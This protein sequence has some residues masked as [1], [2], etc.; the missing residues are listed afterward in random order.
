MKKKYPYAKLLLW[1]MAVLYVGYFSVFTILRIKGLYSHYFDLG[2]MHQTVFNT[3]EAIRTFDWSRFMELANPHGTGFV[4]RMAVHNDILL[5]VLAPLYFIYNGPQTLVVLQTF[6]LGAGA[7]AVFGIVRELM[8]KAKNRD[9]LAVVFVFTYLMYVPMQR[10]NIFDFHAVTFATTFI[11]CMFY[12]WLKKRYVLSFLFV[13]LT[14]LT[15]EQIG[16]TTFLIAG[17]M[18]VPK[19]S[20]RH[21]RLPAR[22]EAMSFLKDHGVR[23]SLIVMAVS[24]AWFV[25]SMKVIIP[26]YNNGTHFAIGYYSVFK[27]P[28][29]IGHYI[30][31]TST[32][33]YFLYL[34]GPLAFL[35][36]VSPLFFLASGFEFAINLLSDEWNMRNIIYHYTAVITPLL[37][38][39]AIY[40]AYRIISF[41]ARHKKEKLATG[42]IASLLVGLTLFFSWWKGPLPYSLE[43]DIFPLDNPSPG[44]NEVAQWG[45]ILK[46]EKI[47][48]SSNGHLAPFFSSRRYYYYFP[49]GYDKADYVV[50]QLSELYNY[51]DPKVDI[52]GMYRRLQADQR[53]RLIYQGNDIEVYQKA[54][55]TVNP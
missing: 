49:N 13:F 51:F 16:P 18:L 46:N 4:K 31:Q 27:N 21:L 29:S 40:G 30:F 17:A 45:K 38:I 8:K 47:S 11:L 19:I 3:Y 33:D 9:L 48:V 41:A 39:S 6:V 50:V 14:L 32:Y 54:A 44:S 25:I 22:K 53:Y 15:K 20:W 5:A 42:I 1:I 34:L 23:F 10:S 2:I 37:F 24:L 35:S 55:L 12:F 36:L 28:G 52:L 43:K 7:F 26:H